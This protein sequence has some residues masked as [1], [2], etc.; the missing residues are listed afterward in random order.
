MMY[1]VFNIDW[2]VEDGV[3]ELPDEM[4]VEIDYDCDCLEDEIADVISDECG[5]CCYGFD[6]E[7]VDE[8]D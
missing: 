2:D 7:K 4:I 6:F 8:G 3:E 1:R 5:W